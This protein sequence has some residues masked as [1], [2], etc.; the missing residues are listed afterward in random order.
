M[1]DSPKTIRI[2]RQGGLAGLPASATVSFSSLTDAQRLEVTRLLQ[3]GGTPAAP[4]ADRYAFHLT[5][6]L[7]K[8]PVVLGEDNVPKWLTQLLRTDIPG[9]DD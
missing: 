9:I 2:V 5:T 7:D 8:A 4:G 6:D 3:S 1:A